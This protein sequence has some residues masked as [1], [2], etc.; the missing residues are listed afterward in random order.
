MKRAAVTLKRGALCLALAA[1][2][3]MPAHGESF[4]PAL[5]LQ[6]V[7]QLDAEQVQWSFAPGREVL[8]PGRSTT[9][10][11]RRQPGRP[12]EAQQPFNPEALGASM[13]AQA[14]RMRR[15][16]GLQVAEH[17]PGAEAWRMAIARG[18]APQLNVCSITLNT[19][20]SDG[21]QVANQC[22]IF[23]LVLGRP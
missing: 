15:E 23:G 22:N 6:R 18:Q 16:T 21:L 17:S 8:R 12:P 4:S 5:N 11:S 7:P 10:Q 20:A 19:P 9:A 3:Q 1:A 13:S 14:R 2:V